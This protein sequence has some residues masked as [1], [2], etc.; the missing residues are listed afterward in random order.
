SSFHADFDGDDSTQHVENL[1][2]GQHYFA[3]LFSSGPVPGGQSVVVTVGTRSF[4]ISRANDVEGHSRSE[5]QWF[6][7]SVEV[8]ISPVRGHDSTNRDAEPSP[9]PSPRGRGGRMVSGCCKV[10]GR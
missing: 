5:F 2:Q 3:H 6:I 1:T 10:R 4:D 8:R 7:N 9:R